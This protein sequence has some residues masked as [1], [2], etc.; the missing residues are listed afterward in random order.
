MTTSSQ[1][2]PSDYIVPI[3]MNG[4][5]GRMLRLPA[6]AKKSKEILFIYGHHS[7]LERWWGVAQ[8][9]NRY[10][11]VTLPDLPGFGGMDS[12]YN[13]GRR[14][15]VD[16]LADYLASFIKLRY[17]KRR[18]T[19]VSMSFGFV[20]V[21]RMLQRYPDLA[22]KIDLLV[23]I[24]G[25]TNGDE[26]TFSRPRFYAYL[27]ASRFFSR[28]LPAVFFKNVFLNPGLIKS[29]YAR[30]HNAKSKFAGLSK[31]DKRSMI[32]FEVYLWHV[33]DVRTHMYTSAAFLTV[34][35]LDRKADLHLH[36]V[37]VSADQYFDAHAVEQHLN[38]IFPVVTT[39]VAKLDRHAPS[40]IANEKQAARLLPASIKRLLNQ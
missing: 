4:L 11:S 27:A 16:N 8:V 10:G 9:L 20:V 1:K 17:K 23:S 14:P 3:N 31:E 36:H 39:H 30:T 37:S 18:I 28:R 33:N 32:D 21:T 35:N 15:T 25:F 2:V 12:F 24:A 40:I 6:P 13:I 29:A 19:L 5:K 26:F 7:S 22:K 34:N 38:I